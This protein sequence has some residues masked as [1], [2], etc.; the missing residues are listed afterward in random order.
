MPLLASEMMLYYQL[1]VLYDPLASLLGRVPLQLA[2]I[3]EGTTLPYQPTRNTLSVNNCILSS[4][5]Q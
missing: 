1:S 3:G 5:S 4:T 2:F